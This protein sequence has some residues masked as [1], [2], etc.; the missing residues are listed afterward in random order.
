MHINNLRHLNYQQ[1]QNWQ[2]DIVFDKIYGPTGQ[3]WKSKIRLWS[4][5]SYMCSV[6]I[7]HTGNWPSQW[8]CNRCQTTAPPNLR[9][10][11]EHGNTHTSVPTASSVTTD[12][13][14]NTSLSKLPTRY[15]SSLIRLPPLNFQVCMLP[16]LCKP[17]STSWFFTRHSF[18]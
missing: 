9:L 18:I 12:L 1:L 10:H 15:L 5:M 2:F 14:F 16:N 11:S 13:L 8:H 7:K 3:T 4:Q 17:H 6:L